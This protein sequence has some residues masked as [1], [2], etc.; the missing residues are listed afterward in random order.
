MP[1]IYV[2]VF[3]ILFKQGLIASL[4]DITVQDQGALICCCVI[5]SYILDM[6]QAII[7]LTKGPLPAAWGPKE[8]N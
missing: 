2:R 6:I 7:S 1:R 8:Y 5:G 3:E 4:L